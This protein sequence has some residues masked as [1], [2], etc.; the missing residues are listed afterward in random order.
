MALVGLKEVLEGSVEKRFAVGAFDAMDHL[1][2]E[3]VI[4]GAEE[5]NTPVILMVGDFYQGEPGGLDF[6]NFYPYLRDRLERAKVPVCLHFDHG[7]SFEACVRA[8]RGGCTSVMID[9]S[10]LPFEENV[11]LTKKVVEMAHASGVDVEAEIGCVGKQ[12]GAVEDGAD[13]MYTRPEDAAEFVARTGVDAL[14]VAVGTVHGVYRGEPKMD[15]NRL[16]KIRSMVSIPLVMHGGSG[17][18]EE[19]FKKAIACG[20]NKINAYT[21]LMLE[22]RRTL[23]KELAALGENDW[24]APAF[25][26]AQMAG[27]DA[28]IKH[29]EL[30]G[31][32]SIR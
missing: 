19:N 7:S 23:E 29:I 1:F 21:G 10:A 20:I 32:P 18:S 11:A 31:T 4:A 16:E 22:V 2:A 26:K 9:G 30:F 3:A 27:K 25:A 12:E 13:G 8:V 5:K 6:P 17:L 24:Y 28:V 15:F 14:A